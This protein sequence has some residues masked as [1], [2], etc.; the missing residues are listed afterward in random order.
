MV[1]LDHLTNRISDDYSLKFKVELLVG[2]GEFWRYCCWWHQILWSSCLRFF[3]FFYQGV[4]VSPM[5]P[6]KIHQ[7]NSRPNIPHHSKHWMLNRKGKYLQKGILGILIPSIGLWF[8]YLLLSI[9]SK[10]QFIIIRM[11][12]RS[13]R[14]K[15]QYHYK[16]NITSNYLIFSEVFKSTLNRIT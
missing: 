10:T 8:C 2:Y 16:S 3:Y 9:L 7:T 15:W 11:P 5:G 4:L 12:C 14:D 1:C 13:L 6:A